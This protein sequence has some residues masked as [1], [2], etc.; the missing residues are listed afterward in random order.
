MVGLNHIGGVGKSVT[1][2][3]LGIGLARLDKKVI[4]LDVD[5][6]TSL[7]ISH[8]VPKPKQHSYVFVMA[9]T[10]LGHQWVLMRR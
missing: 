9:I 2:A 4:V 10:I 3:S 1:T 8:D 5:P 6:Q 7:T